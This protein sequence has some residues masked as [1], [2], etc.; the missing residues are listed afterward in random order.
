MFSFGSESSLITPPTFTSSK[1]VRSPGPF[2]AMKILFPYVCLF[3]VIMNLQFLFMDDNEPYHRTTAVEELLEAKDIES[4]DWLLRSL[5][6]NLIEDVWKFLGRSL[7]AVT[8]H[9]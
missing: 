2:I 3:R 5:D 8:Y 7:T 4:M 9:Q 1:E 6:L